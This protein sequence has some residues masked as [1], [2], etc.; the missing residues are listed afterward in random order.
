MKAV[1]K[2]S[3]LLVRCRAFAADQS[4][5]ILMLFAF[6]APIAL[7]SR[8]PGPRKAQTF[9][10]QRPDRRAKKGMAEGTVRARRSKVSQISP[11]YSGVARPW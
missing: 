1:A 10:F 6:S 5:N 8:A 3:T 4:G 9:G 2:F 7:G 11:K